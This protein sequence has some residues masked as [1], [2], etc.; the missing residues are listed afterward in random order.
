M[1][2]V[3]DTGVSPLTTNCFPVGLNEQNGAIVTKGVIVA[4]YSVIPPDGVTY[5]LTGFTLMMPSAP[6][7][8]GTLFGATV[9][10]T[11]IVN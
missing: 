9:F 8:A 10:C 3:E 4:Q 5:P 7:P 2:T 11:V 6:L 1:V